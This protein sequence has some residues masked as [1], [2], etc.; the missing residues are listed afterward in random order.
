MTENRIK[1]RMQYARET[2]NIF[3]DNIPL[4][5][6]WLE[7]RLANLENPKETKCDNCDEMVV[8]VKNS[9]EFCPNC[10]C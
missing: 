1:L 10:F 6:D 3:S 2:D 8:M 4:Y 7:T 5:A 9:D